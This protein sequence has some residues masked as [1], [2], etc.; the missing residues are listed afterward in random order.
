MKV[1]K[2]R[3]CP[4]FTCLHAQ[5][6]CPH[7]DTHPRMF[8]CLQA[9]IGTMGDIDA[10][11]LPDAKGYAAMSRYLLGVSDEE[12]QQ[13]RDEILGTSAKD[14]KCAAWRACGVESVGRGHM[15]LDTST[16]RTYSARCGGCGEETC[17]G[18]G[19]HCLLGH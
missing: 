17:G 16:N 13:R 12:R 1:S 14:F 9:I 18:G 15:V 8:V 19:R 2:A 5:I 10:Y 6:T 4:Y 7:F 11:Q 3:V